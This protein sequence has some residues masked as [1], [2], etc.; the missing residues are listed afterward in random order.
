MS[1]LEKAK[2][3]IISCEFS[4]ENMDEMNLLKEYESYNI[5]KAQEKQWLEEEINNIITKIEQ[6]N[7]INQYYAT[8]YLRYMN[9]NQIE[10][11]SRAVESNK[12]YSNIEKLQIYRAIIGKIAVRREL[13]SKEK[14]K[15][16]Y[17]YFLNNIQILSKE[18]SIEK[19]YAESNVIPIIKGIIR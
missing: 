2:N 17:D 11:L 8:Q 12:S 14:Q 4:Y 1:D 18:G 13:Y 9:L 16:I 7:E 10:R 19:K 5:S 6:N 15:E 3:I